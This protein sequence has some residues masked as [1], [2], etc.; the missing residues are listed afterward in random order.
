LAD[1]L[2]GEEKLFKNLDLL[3][4]G[5]IFIKPDFHNSTLAVKYNKVIY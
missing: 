1:I 5:I 2:F 3:A 4:E